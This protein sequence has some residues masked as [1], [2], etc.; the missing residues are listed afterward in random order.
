MPPHPSMGAG[1]AC[2]GPSK[3][4][5]RKAQL[6][7][8]RFHPLMKRIQRLH[9]RQERERSGLFYI[10][11][12]RF[13]AMALQHHMPVETLVV[14]PS[15]LDHPYAQKMIRTQRRLG[16]PILEVTAGVMHSIT[17]VDDPQGIGA[18]VRQRWK[19]LERIKPG[20][21]LCWLALQIIRSPGNLGTILRTC[22]C[23]GAA[24]LILLGDE[25]DPYDPATVRATMGAMFTQSFVR[26]SLEKFIQWKRRY[27]IPLVG[28]SPSAP[29]DYQAVNYQKPTILLMGEERKGLPPDLQ[30]ICDLMVNIPMVGES[31]SLNLGIATGVMLYELFNQG[32]RATPL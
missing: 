4:T 19:P 5:T 3:M 20:A 6:I 12:L 23:V 32:R 28:T 1:R 21:E 31:D 10:E 15:L 25:I 30:N 14:C 7:D 22:D 9:L 24:G 11:G 29:V 8:S 13:V 17:L 2:N 16:T 18:I 27:T 26:T